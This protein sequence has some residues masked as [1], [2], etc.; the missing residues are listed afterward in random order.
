MEKNSPESKTLGLASWHSM[1]CA[2]DSVMKKNPRIYFER[3]TENI[4][5]MFPV[6]VSCL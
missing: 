6:I 3:K 4:P 5:A 2:Q 1:R